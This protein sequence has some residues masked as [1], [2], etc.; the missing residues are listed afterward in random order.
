[1]IPTAAASGMRRR[2]GPPPAPI[3]ITRGLLKVPGP[4]AGPVPGAGAVA[5]G[6]VGT[7]ALGKVVLRCPGAQD[8]DDAVHDPSVVDR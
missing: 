2:T 8:E 3:V 5:A 1:M 6:R 7:M 4:G